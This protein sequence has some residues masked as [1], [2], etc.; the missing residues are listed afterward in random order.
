MTNLTEHE[1]KVP[2]RLP[3]APILTAAA[4]GLAVA[5]TPVREPIELAAK[6]LF[7]LGLFLNYT[8]IGV[9]IALLPSFRP[10]WLFG[11]VVGIAYSLPGALFTAVP[12]PLREDAPLYFH[13]FMAGGLREAAM[14]LLVGIATGLFAGL[15]LRR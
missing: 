2:R 8:S 4:F 10:R 9:L 11:L 1:A 6:L 14:T 7:G 15:S 12:V 5:L 3:Y 13:S